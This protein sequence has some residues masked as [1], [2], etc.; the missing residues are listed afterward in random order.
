MTVVTAAPYAQGLVLELAG[1]TV[2][3][4]SEVA[5]WYDAERMPGVPAAQG[6]PDAVDR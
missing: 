3:V 1:G 6:Q 4:I 2:G 5:A